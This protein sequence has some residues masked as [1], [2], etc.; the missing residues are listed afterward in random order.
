MKLDVE[1]VKGLPDDHFV[2]L[3]A[4]ELGMYNGSLSPSL[5]L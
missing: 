5:P 3:K 2:V 1:V 4:I